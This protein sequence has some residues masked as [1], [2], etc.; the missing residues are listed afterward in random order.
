[1]GV[2]LHGTTCKYKIEDFDVPNLPEID[3]ARKQKYLAFVCDRQ[4][5]TYENT[6]FIFI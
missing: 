4:A 2:I 3:V 1:M 5:S 6:M